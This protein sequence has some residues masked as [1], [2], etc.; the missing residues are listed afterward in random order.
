MR[1]FK[2][3]GGAWRAACRILSGLCALAAMFLGS[4]L[5]YRPTIAVVTTPW[6]NMLP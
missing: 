2:N 1:H 6:P 5:A 4:F 3:N